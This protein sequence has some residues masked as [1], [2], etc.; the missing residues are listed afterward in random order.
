MICIFSKRIC[1]VLKGTSMKYFHGIKPSVFNDTSNYIYIVVSGD[2]S[3]YIV[4]S[5]DQSIYIVV[6]G[7]QSI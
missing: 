7:D 6:S 1:L 4:V 2:Q 3:I 5:G